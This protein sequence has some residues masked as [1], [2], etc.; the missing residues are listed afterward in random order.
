MCILLL[1]LPEDKAV[2]IVNDLIGQQTIPVALLEPASQTNIEFKMR[3][4]AKDPFV[5]DNAIIH[6]YRMDILADLKAF[7]IA[8]ESTL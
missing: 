2:I 7:F 4:E 8:V 6:G 1:L 5:I 3:S